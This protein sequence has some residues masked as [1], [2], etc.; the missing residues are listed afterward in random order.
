MFNNN[1]EILIQKNILEL[2]NE[3]SN[4]KVHIKIKNQTL[5]WNWKIK[6]LFISLN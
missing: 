5:K 4:L 2:V 1:Y 6:S 3:I